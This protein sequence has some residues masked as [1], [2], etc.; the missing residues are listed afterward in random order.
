MRGLPAAPEIE[1]AVLGLIFLN[2]LAYH[3]LVEA[4]LRVD[5][6]SLDANRRIFQVIQDLVATRVQPDML[7]VIESLKDRGELTMVGDVSYVSNLI[8]GVPDRTGTLRDYVEI[9]G[10]RYMRRQAIFMA[11][12]VASCAADP[13]DPIRNTVAYANE[14]LLRLQGDNT[15]APAEFISVS[16]QGVLDDISQLMYVEREVIGI[17]YGVQ[18]LDE[19]TTGLRVGEITTVG[20]Y[21]GSAKTAFALNVLRLAAKANQPV[22]FFS[23]EMTSRELILRLFA[24]ESGISYS[25]LRNPRNLSTD[26]RRQLDMW[27][28]RLDK[29]PLLIDDHVRTVEELVPRAHLYVRKHGIKLIAIDYLQLIEAPGDTEYDRV[30]AASDAIWWL[31]KATQVPILCLSQLNRPEG[32]NRGAIPLPTLHSLRSSGKIE[33]NT[34]NVLLLHRAYD[35]EGA[36][37]GEDWIIIAKQR[38]GLVG[39]VKARFDGPSQ[40]WDDRELRPATTNQPTIFQETTR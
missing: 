39:R 3:E 40:I 29:L 19:L 38:A 17:S 18:D 2:E 10:D 27:K 21:P 30:S 9:L 12:R 37:T 33:Q 31:E 20:G 4:G 5:Y 23:L 15:K 36:P 26:E 25:K 32:R 22:V 34:H 6:F 1:T 11:N 7:M 8:T 24:Q 13:S 35:D 14:D 16:T 28:E